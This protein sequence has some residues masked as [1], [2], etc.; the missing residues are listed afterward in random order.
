VRY[1]SLPTF[2]PVRLVGPVFVLG[3]A[4]SLA[5]PLPAI[6]AGDDHAEARAA[7]ADVEAAINELV[8]A[9]ASY[10]TDRNVYRRASQRAMNALAGSRGEGYDASAGSAGD[11]AGAIGHID[12]LLDR[13]DKPV[14]V[15]PLH[16]AEA[17]I[18]AAVVHLHDSLKAREL[19]DYEISASRALTYLEVARGRPTDVGVLAGIEGALANTELGVPAGATRQDGCAGPSSAPAYGVHDG[20]LA[21]I[22]APGSEGTHALAESPGGAEIA[23]HN[24]IVALRTAA[25]A[26]VAKSCDSHTSTDA[27]TQT[28]VAQTSAPQPASQPA[29][30]AP[31]VAPLPA[32]YTQEQ[33]A[34]GAQIYAQ[35][36]V[37]C[38]GQNLQGTAAPSV[39]GTDFLETAE[40][41]SWTLSIVRYIVF[42]LMPRNAPS[43][44][45]PE[46]SAAVMAYLLA[47]DCYPAGT[48]PFPA[49]DNPALAG[50][51]LGPPPGHPAGQNDKGVCKVN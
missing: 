42:K 45:G 10:A 50:T 5:T 39:A 35:N 22:A 33:A 27:P 7:L 23:V 46:E 9:D 20:Y 1:F 12:A 2:A 3:I 38:H 11:T 28:A 32:L 16:G 30:A 43:S 40:R 6:A 47:S 19:K 24:G 8:Q 41:N 51:K 37:A 15:D 21:W 49:A 25:G 29:A 34:K 14:W 26:L 48:T 13:R 17:N 44:L 4:A 31:P 18:R 36:C